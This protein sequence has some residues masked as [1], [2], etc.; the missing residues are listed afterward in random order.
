MSMSFEPLRCAYPDLDHVAHFVPDAEAARAS[1]SVMGFTLTPFSAQS[2][3][4]RPDGPLVPAGTG[5]RCV[6]LDHGYLEFLTPTHDTP[7][8]AQLHAAIQRYVGVH[9]IAFG[10]VTPQDD[11]GRLARGGFEPLAPISLQRTVGTVVGDATARFTVVRV[12][13]TAM[14]EGRIQFCQHHTRDV[15]WQPRWTAHPNRATGLAG[16]LLCVADPREAA[17]RYER[18][19]GLSSQSSGNSIRLDC[20]DGRGYLLFVSPE[21]LKQRLG[22]S[23]PALPWICGYVLDS[24]D[25]R[26]T[27][28][29]V[30]GAV[31]DGRWLVDLDA[32]LGG[33]MMFQREGSTPLQIE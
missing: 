8:A 4:L 2:H 22:L 20:A 5:N 6:M 9:L 23:V 16:V 7:N 19:T 13:P 28:G 29:M 18:F 3:R 17:R 32:S 24:S 15:V 31:Y 25:L 30:R 12:A 27:Q 33:V 10:T 1:L 11:F 14:A 21:T 26:V